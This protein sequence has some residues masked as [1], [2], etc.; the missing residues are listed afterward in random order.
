LDGDV[1]KTLFS[2]SDGGGENNNGKTLKSQKNHSVHA[3]KIDE[4]NPYDYGF[5]GRHLQE[6]NHVRK[7]KQEELVI[8]QKKILGTDVT[9]CSTTCNR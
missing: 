4:D 2:F 6:L 1:D 3:K 5:M 7:Q 8:V 9:I